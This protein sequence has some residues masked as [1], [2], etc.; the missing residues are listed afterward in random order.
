MGEEKPLNVRVAEALGCDVIYRKAY[1]G[2]REAAWCCE[3]GEHRDPNLHEPWMDNP[4]VANY[5]TDWSAT[6]P[7]IERYGFLLAPCEVEDE[8]TWARRRAWLCGRYGQVDHGRDWLDACSEGAKATGATPLE[9]ASHL[10][11]ALAAAGKLER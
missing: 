11:I 8:E 5:D 4:V 1:P 6:G 9:A 10:I 3:D 7:L 2:D